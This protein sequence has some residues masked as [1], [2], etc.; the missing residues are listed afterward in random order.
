M[1]SLVADVNR[2]IAAVNRSR[3]YVSY[4]SFFQK[5]GLLLEFWLCLLCELFVVGAHA[6]Y[7]ELF[8]K[9]V[10]SAWLP[11]T[12]LSAC[13]LL[14][15]IMPLICWAFSETKFFCMNSNHVIVFFFVVDHTSYVIFFCIYC[16]F[17]WCFFVSNC[18]TVYW[19]SLNWFNWCCILLC[20]LLGLS[21]SGR[22]SIHVLHL[23]CNLPWGFGR[24][25]FI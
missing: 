8:L 7:V 10:F 13:L 17:V 19:A 24:V 22:I 16:D 21:S 11:T 14:L 4:L 25:L 15:L 20:K 2:I 1:T 3:T 23:D 18:N 5:K 6:L 9:Q 12:S